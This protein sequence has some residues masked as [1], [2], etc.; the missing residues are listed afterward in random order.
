MANKTSINIRSC[1]IGQSEAHN[2]R[3]KEYME[4]IAKENI[5]LRQDLTYKNSTWI[6]PKAQGV[7]LK[8]YYDMLFSIASKGTRAAM[9]RKEYS[10]VD[11]KTGRIKKISACSPIREGVIV[12]KDDTTIDDLKRFCQ[13]CQNR[14]GITA[15]Q[16][17]IHKDEGHYSHDEAKEWKPNYHAHIIF[18][19]LN[20]ETGKVWSLRRE[21]FSEIQDFAAK[22]LGMQRGISK[23]IT[24]L[25]HLERNEFVISIQKE[26]LKKIKEAL[27]EITRQAQEAEKRKDIAITKEK[28][29]NLNLLLLTE[30]IN[31]LGKEVSQKASISLDLDNLIKQ[32]KQD[33]KDASYAIRNRISHI[34]G[35]GDY[36]EIEKE[37][38]SLKEEIKHLTSNIDDIVSKKVDEKIEPITKAKNE[39]IKKID[40]CNKAL[41]L[42]KNEKEKLELS[43]IEKMKH[44]DN[45]FNQRIKKEVDLKVEEINEKLICEQKTNHELI[46]KYNRLASNFTSKIKDKTKEIKELKA[47]NTCTTKICC[48]LDKSVKTAVNAIFLLGKDNLKVFDKKAVETLKAVMDKYSTDAKGRVLIGEALISFVN[49]E[50]DFSKSELE[51]IKKQ[52]NNIAND[53]YDDNKEII[54]KVG[55]SR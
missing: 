27:N 51:R 40:D 1:N 13:T 29:E 23:K 45:E 48:S 5:Y 17:Y 26:R 12:I 28:K 18:D 19:W 44:L 53:P 21:N 54:S 7:S 52:V 8:N 3:T 15:F 43:S 36:Y 31:S 42:L 39:A 22:E 32:R 35:K 41:V 24:G 6:S 47:I 34:I 55:V 9:K 38:K 30:K 4:N 49:N 50:M 33:A 46:D 2:L 20:H 16:I 25:R 10:R 14:L 11:K 37:N